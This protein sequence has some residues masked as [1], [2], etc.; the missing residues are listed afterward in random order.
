MEVNDLS[1]LG[2]L[3]FGQRAPET[4]WMG[5]WVC[6]GFVGPWLP[7]CAVLQ[8]LNIFRC[9]TRVW[10]VAQYVPS[11]NSSHCSMCRQSTVHIAVCAVSQQF[12]L[13]YVPS[14]NSS[15]Y[16]MCR[17]PTANSRRYSN[18]EQ[19]CLQ[20]HGSYAGT[21]LVVA[22]GRKNVCYLSETECCWWWPSES[23]LRLRSI[24]GAQVTYVVVVVGL[25][26]ISLVW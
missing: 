23:V 5:T 11:A 25:G 17:Q 24:G 9:S 7:D 21:G 15:H 26:Y 4:Y 10:A 2:R 18:V 14:A 20:F 16:N 3:T 1:C 19:D 6:P 8:P 12:T 22:D 13:Q